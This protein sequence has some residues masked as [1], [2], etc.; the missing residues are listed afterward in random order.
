MSQDE[1]ERLKR[2]RDRQIAARNPEKDEQKHYARIRSQGRPDRRQLTFQQLLDL[3][4]SRLTWSLGGMAFGLA[5]GIFSALLVPAWGLYLLS[6][7]TAIGLVM[8][9][10][11][12]AVRDKGSTWTGR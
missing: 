9:F 4:G 5:F 12:G 11:L 10:V 8:G 7:A 6:G 2:I 1:I 3:A